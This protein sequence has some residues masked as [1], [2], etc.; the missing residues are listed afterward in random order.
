MG[1]VDHE[2]GADVTRDAGE[3]LEIDAQRI[4]RGAGDD[5]LGLVLVRLALHGL[6]VD[7]LLRVKAVRDDVEPLAAHVERHA[8]GQVA[9]FG[10]AHPHDRVARLQ[11]RQEHRFVGLCARVGLHVG[12]V[13]PEQLP[14][15]VDRQLLG[16]VDVLAA[17]VV[18]LAGIALGILVRQLRALR[19]H[20][21]RRG[22]VLAGDQL[23][24][25]FLAAVLRLDRGPQLGV[26]LFDED[27]SSGTWQSCAKVVSLSETRAAQANG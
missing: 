1:H 14:D 17:A 2:D 10:E 23:D 22:V 8:V 15:P 3:T 19:R 4:G 11:E 7:R 24:V 5:Q 12:G 27:V 18:P 26:R 25:L 16:D 21:G 9:A 13:R 20:H 6:V